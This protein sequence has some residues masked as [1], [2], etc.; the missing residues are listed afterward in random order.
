MYQVC[1]FKTLS[2]QSRAEHTVSRRLRW[3]HHLCE[4]FRE[5]S[6][7]FPWTIISCLSKDISPV[8]MGR[9]GGGQP[10]IPN[11]GFKALQGSW[12]GEGRA[13]LKS[14]RPPVLN[15]WESCFG[16]G[17]GPSR[18][19]AAMPSESSCVSGACCWADRDGLAW[20]RVGGGAGAETLYKW[21][22][23]I[24]VQEELQQQRPPS[25]VDIQGGAMLALWNI[26]QIPA[27][28]V[29]IDVCRASVWRQLCSF[30]FKCLTRFPSSPHTH[31]H[32]HS[33]GCGWFFCYP[34]DWRRVKM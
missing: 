15:N 33:T 6:N 4:H 8:T 2:G 20:R 9:C 32:M 16:G 26:H 5:G 28:L 1:K 29:V 19:S 31:T 18:L 34:H 17:R 11:C 30:W 22:L 27:S 14:Y 12:G 13:T 7:S 10:L 25:L 23:M 24:R 3:R 21:H